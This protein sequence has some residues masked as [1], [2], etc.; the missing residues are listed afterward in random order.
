M[1]FDCGPTIGQRLRARRDRRALWHS[2]F[3]WR[4]VRC[5]V[6]DHWPC[7]LTGE[8]R[9]VWLE[10]VERRIHWHGRNYRVKS[11]S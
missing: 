2:W 11:N 1:R 5:E 10:R 4:P 3:A 8:I 6:Y 7:W 9:C